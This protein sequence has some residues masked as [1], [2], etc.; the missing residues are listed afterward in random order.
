MKKS[1]IISGAS[2]GIGGALSRLF[3]REG[4]GVMLCYRQGKERAM[5]LEEELCG[6]GMDAHAV[7]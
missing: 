4:Y 6:L 7:L 5:Q 3:A 2:G 1:V